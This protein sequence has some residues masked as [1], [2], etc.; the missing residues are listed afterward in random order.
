MRRPKL[1]VDVPPL[2]DDQWTGIPVFTRRLIEALWRE[3]SLDLQFCLGG[4][5]LRSDD[6][7][8][9]IQQ[10]SG[11]FLQQWAQRRS[12]AEKPQA[13]RGVPTFFPSVKIPDALF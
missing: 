8:R 7:R 2:L 4:Q 12:T 5:L 10:L 1:I 13:R 6:V 9:A 11:A 3:G